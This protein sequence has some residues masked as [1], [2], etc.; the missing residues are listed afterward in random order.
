MRPCGTACLFL[1]AVAI[2]FPSSCLTSG[3]GPSLWGFALDGYPITPARIEGLEA[4]TGLHPDMVVFFLQWPPLEDGSSGEFPLESLEAIT[5]TGALPCI[6]WEPMFVM[7]GREIAI[8]HADVLG[9]RYDRYIER[10][11]EKAR[12]WRKPL[13]MRFAHE[14][15]L[16]RYHWGTTENKYGPESPVIY[17]KMYRYVV[18]IFK[19]SGAGNVLWVFCPNA[20]SVPGTTFDPSAS[21]NV[22]SAYYPGDDYVD[23][24]GVDGYNWGTTRKKEIHGWESGWRSFREIFEAPVA[25][26]KGLSPSARQKPLVVFETATVGTGGNKNEWIR[27]AMSASGRLGIEGI[28]WFQSDKEVDWR[29]ESGSDGSHVPA[30]KGRR[31]T[32]PRRLDGLLEKGGRP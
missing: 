6:T 9:G 32:G 16:K 11:A 2:L 31:A 28:V 26:L 24:L 30:V 27:D 3:T 19:R 25:E 14:M 1:M 5:A 22:L 21:W 10:F 20:E 15:N 18:E 4:A 7:A 13:L 23:I 12:S 29:I 17:R 8:P